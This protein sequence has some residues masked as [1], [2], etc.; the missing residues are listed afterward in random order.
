M[1]YAD[2]LAR[3]PE[4]TKTQLARG[5]GISRIRV[6]QA[7]SILRLPPAILEF[8]LEHDTPEFRAVL[9]ERRLRRLTAIRD[10]KKQLELFR[11]LMRKG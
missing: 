9:T 11:Q 8:I 6:Y 2:I 5:L 10:H 4:L 1:L 3:N 7:L